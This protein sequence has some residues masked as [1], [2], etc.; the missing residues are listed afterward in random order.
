MV[1]IMATHAKSCFR[2]ML[3]TWYGAPR[4]FW[5]VVAALVLLAVL[6]GCGGEPR[7]VVPPATAAL[8]TFTYPAL[9]APTAAEE[10]LSD[11]DRSASASDSLYSGFGNL[12]GAETSWCRDWSRQPLCLRAYLKHAIDA[13]SSTESL[14]GAKRHNNAA[15]A[16]RHCYWSARMTWDFGVAHA[17]GFG[18]RHEEV[19]PHDQSQA[20]RTMDLTNNHHGRK[21]GQLALT[22]EAA[23]DLCQDWS[24]DGTL[25]TSP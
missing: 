14:F 4:R 25:Q 5:P 7:A 20:E 23:S 12:N 1:S 6:S 19:S 17:K 15:D 22:Y 16:Y 8:A 11:K 2:G 13:R 9:P 18:D 10:L 24:Q 21:A 3:G